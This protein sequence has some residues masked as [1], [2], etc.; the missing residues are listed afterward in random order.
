[1]L[2]AHAVDDAVIAC[3]MGGNAI[4]LFDLK[5]SVAT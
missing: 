5:V 4:R 3:L 1:M 2:R